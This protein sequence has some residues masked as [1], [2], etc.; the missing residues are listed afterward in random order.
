M[1][2]PNLKQQY[3]PLRSKIILAF[4]GMTMGIADAIPG[5]SGGTIALISGI[6]DHLIHAISSVGPSHALAALQLLIFCWHGE[7]RR[8]ALERLSE[9]EWSFLIPLLIG[10]LCALVFM[11]FFIPFILEHYAYFAYAFF[12]GLIVFSISIPFR[13]MNRRPLEF[14]LI[15]VAAVVVFFVVGLSR[16]ADATITLKPVT[17][18]TEDTEMPPPLQPISVDAKGEWHLGV[19]ATGAVYA[20][21]ITASGGDSLGTFSVS[22]TPRGDTEPAVEFMDVELKNV[23]VSFEEVEGLAADGSLDLKMRLSEA[24][25]R[26]FLYVLFSGALAICAMI[27]PG[28]SGAYILVILGEYKLIAS[29]GRDLVK[30]GIDTLRSGSLDPML[31][32]NGLVV[33]AFV[34]GV[35]IGILSFVR[36]LRFF[37]DRY[38]SLTMAV[39]TG[40]MIGSLRGIWPVQHLHGEELSTGYIIGGVALAIG[41]GIAIFALEQI[42]K[43]LQDPEPPV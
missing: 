19:P 21:T 23:E 3:A 41:G 28:I 34:L 42:S 33:L 20:G 13:M 43:K 25:S 26:G 7:R 15:V 10:I 35:L 9:I 37:L 18:L 32:D 24:G 31:I 14:V 38:H 1:T 29:A 5:V 36:L 6:Y 2:E 16:I 30:G 22:V 11:L 27:L 4:K 8:R 39:L 12:F 40:L 17:G